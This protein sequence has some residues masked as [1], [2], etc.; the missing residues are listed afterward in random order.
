[1]PGS[2]RAVPE[3]L[4]D[5]Q[6]A[7]LRFMLEDPDHWVQRTKWERFLADGNASTTVKTDELTN[8]HKVAALAWLRQ[9]R[10]K[11]HAALEGGGP[12]PAGWLE[13]FPLYERLGGNAR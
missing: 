5:E 10:H 6:R 3:H 13:A 4:D 2:R 11:L 9:Q 12:A 7:R 8:D 1:M